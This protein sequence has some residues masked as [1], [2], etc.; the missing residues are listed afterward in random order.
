MCIDRLCGREELERVQ[1]AK[2]WECY[3]CSHGYS[4]LG[5]LCKRDNWLDMLKE[6][7]SNDYEVEYVR[8]LITHCMGAACSMRELKSE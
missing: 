4:K 6:L 8:M 3:L 2:A 5:L 1:Q 7:F